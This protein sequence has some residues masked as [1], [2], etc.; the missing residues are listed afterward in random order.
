MLTIIIVLNKI[1]EGRRMPATSVDASGY[2]DPE[3]R[4]F[5]LPIDA[6]S[7]GRYAVASHDPDPAYVD[8]QAAKAAGYDRAIAPP[9]F[10]AAMLD[11]AGGPPEASLRR[12][13]VALDWFPSIIAPE[14]VLMGGGQ[15]IDFLSTIY[16]GDVV[17]IRR[18]LVEHT[19][20]PSNRFGELDFV[21]VESHVTNQDGVLVMRILDTLIV[22]Q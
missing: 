18:S 7:V 1:A 12:D 22:A 2:L 6:V 20:R 9:M 19:R 16:V 8:D 21:V 17:E 13:G 3:T 5:T 4:T 11:Y 10:V 15:D 14:A